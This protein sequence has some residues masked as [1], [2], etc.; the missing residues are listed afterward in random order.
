[1]KAALERLG[2]NKTH[3][4]VEVLMPKDQTQLNYWDAVGR[5]ETVD[6]H[7]V[8]EGYEACVDFPSSLYWRELAE[9]FPEAK[10]VLTVR[11]FEGWYK[12]ASNTIY[13][14]SK[15]APSWAR[16]IPKPRKIFRMAH[17]IIWGG[18]FGDK[19]ED[20]AHTQK[21][22]EDHIA[23]VK[24]GLP[25]ERLLVFQVK[26]GWEP[27]CAFLDVPVPDE[28]FPRLND[29]EQFASMIKGM[30]RLQYVPFIMAGLLAIGAAAAFFAFQ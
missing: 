26:E 29:A 21:V 6:W 7:A 2:Y 18:K 23:E 28:P 14:V 17:N 25:P 1:M 3:H 5:G 20:K 10:V 13:K 24:A 8:F 4:M 27:L 11:E 19:F 12:S 16:L 9:A 15:S 22:F 30:Q